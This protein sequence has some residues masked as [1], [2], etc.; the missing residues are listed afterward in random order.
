M[1]RRHRHGISGAAIDYALDHHSFLDAEQRAALRWATRANGLSI[2]EGEAGTGKSASLAAIRDAYQAGG[3]TIVGL[4]W[5]NAVVQDMRSGGFDRA[6]TIAAELMRQASGR[7]T[8]NSR[9]VLMVDEAAMIST[10]HLAALMTKAEA[11]GAKVILAGDD[12][13]LASIEHGGLFWRLEQP[14][15][16]RRA[17]HRPARQGRRPKRRVQRHAPRRFPQRH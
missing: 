15:W 11:A 3:F 9:T 6:S 17:S 12:R 16:R 5:T 4:S 1:D 13:Q 8:W 7:A 14:A 2:I 10:K